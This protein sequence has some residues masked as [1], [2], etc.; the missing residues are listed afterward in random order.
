MTNQELLECGYA[1]CRIPTGQ[2]G[3]TYPGW[4]TLEGCITDPARCHELH[5]YNVGLVHAYCK[6]GPTCAIDI[7][8]YR[9]SKAWL[10]RQGI[11]LNK[12]LLKSDAVIVHS[13]KRYSIKPLYRLPDGVGPLESKKINGPAGGCA[14]EFRCGTKDGK[15][16]QD[17]LPP[18][19]HPAGGQ[20]QWLGDGDPRDLPTLPSEMLLLWQQLLAQNA[21]TCHRDRLKPLTGYHRPESPREIANLKQALAHIDADCSYE[22]WRNIVWGVL[23][24]GWPCAEELAQEWSKSASSRYEDGAFRLVVNSYIADHQIKISLGTVYHHARL[25]GWRG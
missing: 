13:G 8:N 25:G 16:V 24:T 18:S 6:P 14:L 2:K 17:V 22:L 19:W 23:S 10:S 12:L 7:D 21:K 20:Y 9:D 11:S 4:N 5:G 1:L 15:S 3:P